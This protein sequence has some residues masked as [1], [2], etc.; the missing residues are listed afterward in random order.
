DLREYAEE[1]AQLRIALEGEGVL[2]LG[3]VERDGADLTL[4]APAEVRGLDVAAVHLCA[5]AA[6]SDCF[7]RPSSSKRCAISARGRLPMSRSIHSSWTGV[8]ASKNCLPAAVS[9]MRR[10]RR[11]P[12]SGARLTRPSCNSASVR[13]V[14]LPLVTMSREESSPMVSPR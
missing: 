14:T 5:P 8:M 2:A 9:R 10:L 11:S 7:S 4:N 1:I 3:P 6:A 13:P 12:G